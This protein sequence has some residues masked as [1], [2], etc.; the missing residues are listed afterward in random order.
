MNLGDLIFSA[1][2][3]NKIFENK[4]RILSSSERNKKS[5]G[6]AWSFLVGLDEGSYPPK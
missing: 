2:P 4:I 6:L 3:N 1:K 5:I